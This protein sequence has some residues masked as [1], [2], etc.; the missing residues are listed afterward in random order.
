[1]CLY[2]LWEES[3]LAWVS[4]GDPALGPPPCILG[5]SIGSVS[6]IF[7]AKEMSVLAV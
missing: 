4:T 1:M 5:F 3:W 6:D 2:F 7:G